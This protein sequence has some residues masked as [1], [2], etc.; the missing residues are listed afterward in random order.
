[1]DSETPTPIE[2]DIVVLLYWQPLTWP[3]EAF[4]VPAPWSEF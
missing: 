3:G 2:C 1:M 4:T